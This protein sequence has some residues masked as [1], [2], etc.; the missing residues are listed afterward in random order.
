EELRSAV[1][2]R[3]F[4]S[5][6]SS[7]DT[8][9]G[10]LLAFKERFG[11]CN[12][13][14]LWE[15]DLS[16]ARWVT[17][18]RTR[19]GKDA[20][21]NEQI[22]RLNS[23]GF[24]W[25][26]QEH[27][28][29]ENWNRWFQELT[30]FKKQFGHCNTSTYSG[31][32][33]LA[34][35]VVAQRVLKKKG[36]LTEAQ[37]QRM[38]DIGFVWDFQAQKA[39]ATWLKWYSELETYSREHGNPH[40]PRTHHNSKLASWVWIQRQRRKGT[41]KRGDKQDL[42]TPDQANL[43]DKLGFRWDAREDKWLEKI[44]QLKQ[45][46]EQHGHCDL[47]EDEDLKSWAQ[48]QRSAQAEGKL[49]PE[50][51]AQLD[52][53]GFPW[54]GNLDRKWD[55]MYDRLKQYHA[56]NGHSDV[57][58]K[59]NKDRKLAG[60]LSAQRQR[61]KKG[62]MTEDEI[63]LLDSLGV[64]WRSRDVGTWEDRLAELVLFKERNGHCNAPKSCSEFPKLGGFVNAMRSKKATG[65]LSQERIG[66]LEA[67]GFQ[68]AVRDASNED[69]WD[70]RFQ[71]LIAYKEAH[72]NCNVPSEWSENAQLGHWVNHQRG[73][74]KRGDMESERKRRLDEIGFDWR[75]AGGQQEWTTRYEQL[76]AYKAQFGHCKV[77]VNWSE[78]PSLGVWARNQRHRFKSGKL[79][80]ENEQLLVEVGFE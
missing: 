73:Y 7:W 33:A 42:M 57:P 52:A 38:N 72:G 30:Q 71:Q 32:P 50:R 68:W 64:T 43:L 45:F 78:N 25:N 14:T 9:F 6:F 39:Q 15:E 17:A 1:T 13:E 51:K 36:E 12:V 47:S 10:K 59:W 40:V 5:L 41:S 80:P 49:E 37:I 18:Q 75:L 16:L 61:R 46:Q 27:S 3:C 8:Y 35:W 4:E 11:H 55:E 74:L 24:V 53:L 20:L 23:I 69:V 79:S 19:R 2:T 66:L 26:W 44:S 56:E 63:R 21:S 29:D 48:L 76:K 58:A 70:A 28:A 31:D 77:P 62:Q 54:T 22:A 34:R 60:W 65:E 67:I